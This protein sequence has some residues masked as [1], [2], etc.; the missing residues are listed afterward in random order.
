MS[1]AIHGVCRA[2]IVDEATSSVLMAKRVEG[3]LRGGKWSLLGGKI[4]LGESRKQAVIREV[5]EESGLRFEPC[6]EVAYLNEEGWSTYFYAGR[7]SG[8]I[9]LNPEEHVEAG[10]FTAEQIEGLEMA[11]SH[12]DIILGYI[13]TRFAH[14][15]TT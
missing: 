6:E 2:F 3:S 9:H 10:Y 4:D 12:R 11:F 5:M 1:E 7:T 15:A 14:E 8:V 13:R